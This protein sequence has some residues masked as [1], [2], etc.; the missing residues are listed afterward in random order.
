M[1]LDETPPEAQ[2]DDGAEAPPSEIDGFALG[3]VGLAFGAGGVDLVVIDRAG[4]VEE[5]AEQG[6][7]AVVDR[8]AG[9]KAHLVPGLVAPGFLVCRVIARFDHA[10][11]HH[12]K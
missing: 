10:V 5:P 2:V 8:A 12:Q 3:A 4:F 9:E 11:G 1:G 7:L 6:G